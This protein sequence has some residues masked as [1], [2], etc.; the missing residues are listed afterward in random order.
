MKLGNHYKQKVFLEIDRG[1]IKNI[2][3]DKKKKKVIL[4][5]VIIIQKPH[6]T[7]EM[8]TISYNSTKMLF[9]FRNYFLDCT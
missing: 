6:L 3:F 8:N 2:Q 9:R 7:V 1:Q 5:D 4:L